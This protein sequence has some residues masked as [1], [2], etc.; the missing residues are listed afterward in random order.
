MKSGAVVRGAGSGASSTT[1]K[2]II[3]TILDTSFFMLSGRTEGNCFPTSFRLQRYI[4]RANSG[5][6]SWPDLVVSARVLPLSLAFCVYNIYRILI[7]YHIW[8]NELPSNFDLINRSLD[9]SPDSVCPS[10]TADLNKVS[11][12]AWSCA[13]MNDNLIFGIFAPFDFDALRPLAG[14][15]EGVVLKLSAIAAK[16]VGWGFWTGAAGGGCGC[17]CGC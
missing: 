16:P 13:V 6:C 7:S 2:L 5:K 14:A 8:D 1:L 12:F 4:A 10:P 9:L 17:C 15:A 3:S 11:N